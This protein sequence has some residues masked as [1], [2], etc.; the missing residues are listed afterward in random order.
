MDLIFKED[1]GWII[2]DYKTDDFE[3]YPK[4]EKAY[5]EQLKMYAELWQKMTGEK[6]KEKI[7]YPA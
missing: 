4:R 5:Y 6:V 3:K 7:L 1:D 2:V